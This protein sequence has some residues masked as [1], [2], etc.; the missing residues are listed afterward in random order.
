[1][2]H[3]WL[4]LLWKHRE[5]GLLGGKSSHE[6]VL[7][8]LGGRS[9]EK[10]LQTSSSHART[11]L[12]DPTASIAEFFAAPASHVVAPIRLFNPEGTEWTLLVLSSFD[13][14]FE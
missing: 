7:H 8:T 4:W 5:N 11:C 10:I 1:M 2:P 14:F 12:V 9:H 3:H 6:K 13:E